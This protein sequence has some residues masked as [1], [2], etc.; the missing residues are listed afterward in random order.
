MTLPKD[1]EAAVENKAVATESTE[2]D[3][4]PAVNQDVP[5]NK[6]DPPPN[7][8]FV[9]WLQVAGCFALYLNTLYVSISCS[10]YG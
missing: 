6:A 2:S 9:A 5:A 8:G 1:P 7:G 10:S 3:D 4:V